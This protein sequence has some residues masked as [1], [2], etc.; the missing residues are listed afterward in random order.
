MAYQAPTIVASGLTWAQL[1]A[2]GPSAHLEALIAAQVPTATPTAA[3]TIATGTTVGGTYPAGTYYAVNTESSGLG[4]TNAGPAS[5]Q[6]TITAQAA[7]TGT[8][9]VVVS[10]SGGTLTAGIYFGKFTYVDTNLNGAGVHGETLAGTEFTFTQVGTDEPVITIND[11]GLPAWASGRNLY[12]TAHGGASGTEVLAFTGITTTTYT[13]L[14][15]PAASVV[16]PPAVNT[17]TTNIPVVTYPALKSGNTFRNLYLGLL[18]VIN[19]PGAGGSFVMVKPPG[20]NQT[21]LTF[22]DASGVTNNE[23]LMLLR[24]CKQGNFQWVYRY[25]HD[26]TSNFTQGSP[27]PFGSH[28]TKHRRVHAV[29][30]IL[31]TMAQEEGVLFDANPGTIGSAQQG[32]GYQVPLRTWP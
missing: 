1:K 21:G 26:S 3:P 19:S 7:P 16:A 30:A 31:A 18:G 9:T 23:M 28:M 14:A 20:Q 10:G 29:F 15:N 2:G 22:V 4:E 13:I 8:P 17:T 5:A 32:A 6:F 11:G 24:A 12:L 25:L 27:V